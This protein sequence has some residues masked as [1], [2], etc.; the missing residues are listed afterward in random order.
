[1]KKVIFFIFIFIS[2]YALSFGQ[3]IKI[4]AGFDTTR[5]VIGDQIRFIV[6]VEQP[7]GMTLSLSEF[8]DTIVKNIEILS[9]PVTDS[10]RNLKGIINIKKEYLVTSFDS[11]RYQVPPVYAE[12]RNEGG[13]KRFYSDYSF[14]EV[15]RPI[16]APPDTTAKIFDI[17]APYKAPVT[18]G[19]IL[20]WVLLFF[21]AAAIVWFAFRFFKKYRRRETGEE[22]IIIPDPAHIIAFRELEKLREE[23]L[24]QKGEVKEYYSKLTG[25]LR[26]Y[27]ENR[28]KVYSLELTTYE[29]L[30]ALLKTGFKRD[31]SFDKLKAVLSGADMVKFAKYNPEPS[32]NE[33]FY[34][35]AWNFVSETKPEE[36]VLND[37]QKK[38]SEAGGEL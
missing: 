26:Q 33:S 8:K 12:L 32:E 22:V 29:T 15:V 21:L 11:G 6:T 7:A 38:V 4:N 14:L 9:G 10:S 30:N 25:I 19:E 5:I 2:V 24:W 36:T 35:D 28:Y 34:Q 37:S 27:L 20:P 23:K 13:L 31:V 17:V 18:I 3:E 16:V 1:M